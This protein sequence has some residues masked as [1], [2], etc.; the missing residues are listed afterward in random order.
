MQLLSNPTEEWPVSQVATLPMALQ[1]ISKK[2]PANHHISERR[3]GEE[4]LV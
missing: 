2:T 4:P 3:V 1:M